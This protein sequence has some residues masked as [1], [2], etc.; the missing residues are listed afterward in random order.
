MSMKSPEVT[1]FEGGF[2]LSHSIWTHLVD[3]IKAIIQLLSLQ[4]WM[5]ILQQVQQMLLSIAVWNQYSHPL[6]SCAIFWPMAPFG[7]RRILFLQFF[8]SERCSENELAGASYRKRQAWC[9]QLTTVKTSEPLEVTGDDRTTDCK[10]W[11]RAGDLLVWYVAQYYYLT[12]GCPTS[13]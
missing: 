1:W 2:C 8:Q 13:V 5:K 9:S 4:E 7:Y 3:D 11:G 10:G 6:L 12:N